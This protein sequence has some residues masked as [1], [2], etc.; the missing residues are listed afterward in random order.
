MNLEGKKALITGG[1]RGIGA[2][3][4]IDLAKHGADVALNGR[5]DDEEAQGILRQISDL[6]R[7]GSLILGD[8]AI[9]DQ[10]VQCV[11]RASQALGGMDILI[12]SA[13]GPAGGRIEDVSSQLWQSSFAVH[14]DAAFY[15]TKQALPVLKDA[16]E[17]AIVFISSAAGLRGCPGALTY[18]TVKGAILQFTRCS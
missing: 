17:A 5:H 9:E 4:A 1:T 15:L 6:G 7:K 12:H 16:G 13:G 18:C 3:I 14:V 10:A 8:V 11:D 2:A